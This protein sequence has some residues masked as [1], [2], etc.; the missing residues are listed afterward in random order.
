[1]AS[2]SDEILEVASLAAKIMLESGGETYRVEQ[3]VNYICRSFGVLDCESYATPTVIILSFKGEDG[4]IRSVV[5]R[6]RCRSNNL[7][8]IT[9]VSDLSYELCRN[10]NTFTPTIVK[11]KLLAIQNQRS[12]P[13]WLQIVASGLVASSFVVMTDGNLTNFIAAFLVGILVKSFV[14]FWAH[15]KINDF[16][17]NLAGGALASLLGWLSVTVGLGQNWASIV[18]GGLMLLLPGLIMV[19]ALRDIV[20]GDLVSGISRGF[21]AIFIVSAIAAGAAICNLLLLNWGVVL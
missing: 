1:M 15:W 6:I 20:M 4:N 5:R 2:I 18:L 16:I 12:F 11:E 19:N 13:Y 17:I 14:L 8:K 7:A 3:T 21:E 9:D 10:K